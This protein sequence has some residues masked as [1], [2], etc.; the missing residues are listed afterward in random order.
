MSR[1]FARTVEPRVGIEP[2]T[3]RLRIDCSTTELPRPLILKDL[4]PCQTYFRPT[5]IKLPSNCHHSLPKSALC[6]PTLEGFPQ[7]VRNDPVTFRLAILTIR[8]KNA[9]SPFVEYKSRSAQRNTLKRVY[10][11]P[12]TFASSW[13]CRSCRLANRSTARRLEETE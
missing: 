11:C 13:V 3:C 8:W 4:L 5:A 7:P 2:T 12:F 6:S 9:F 10:L 1:D